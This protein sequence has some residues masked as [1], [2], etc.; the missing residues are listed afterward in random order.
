MDV[1][2]ICL[3]EIGMVSRGK[4]FRLKTCVPESKRK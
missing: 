1:L 4:L 2:G 3:K